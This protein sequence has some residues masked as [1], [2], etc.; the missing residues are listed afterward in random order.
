[1]ISRWSVIALLLALCSPTLAAAQ[2]QECG[3]VRAIVR[4]AYPGAVAQGQRSVQAGNRTL[5]LPSASSIDPHAMVCRRWRGRPGLLLVAVPLIAQVRPDST[6]G[7]LDL[8]VVD[9]AAGAPRQRLRIPHAM[10]D[11]AVAISGV[12]FDTA[13]YELEP[14]RLAFGVRREWTGSSRPNPFRET[15]LSLYEVR[16]GT[17]SPVLE[18]LMVSRSVGEWDT[19]CAGETVL[20]ERILRMA[21][22]RR[23]QDISVLERTTRSISKV[24]KGGECSTT[25]RRETPR[26]IRVTFDGGRYVLPSSLR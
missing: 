20:T 24:G 3:D 9:E 16:G 7:D 13:A 17:L 14:G 6:L 4:Q 12:S 2:Q 10:D 21:P 18:N 5:T 19:S 26:T 15:T 11:D 8:L 22:G 1:M 23:A 25:D